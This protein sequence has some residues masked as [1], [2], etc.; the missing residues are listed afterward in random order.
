MMMADDQGIMD[1]VAKGETEAIEELYD[2]FGTLVYRMAYQLTPTK[3]DAED[4]VQEIFV[5]LWQTAERYDVRKAKLVTWVMLIS[6]RYLVDRLRRRRVRPQPS[7]FDEAWTDA[8]L[9][10]ENS[11]ERDFLINERQ[12][13]LRERINGLPE[14]QREVVQRAYLGGRTLREISQELD[15][16][17]GTIKSALSRALAGL[18]DRVAEDEGQ[19]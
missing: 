10:S 13:R 12:K 19:L 8:D 15:R 11:V 17:I 16:P 7:A 5:R 14:L 2:R 1:R 4:A 3:A 9:N 6:R 18:R